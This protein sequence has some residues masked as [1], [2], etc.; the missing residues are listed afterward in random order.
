MLVG[1][2]AGTWL[3]GWLADRT[4]GD[5]PASYALIPACCF[6]VAAPALYNVTGVRTFI[7]SHDGI[8][9]EK[10]LGP[11]TLKHFKNLERFNPDHSWTPVPE[12]QE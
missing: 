11:N 3:G 9:Y 1:G 12:K 7:V 5:R 8:V 4:G 2:V 10:D 6:L